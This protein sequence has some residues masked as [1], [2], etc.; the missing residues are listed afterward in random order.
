MPRLFWAMIACWRIAFYHY[1]PTVAYS[2]QAKRRETL[3]LLDNRP[4]GAAITGDRTSA[5]TACNKRAQARGTVP[6]Q[7]KLIMALLS[8][9]Y[10]AD[11]QTAGASLL[12]W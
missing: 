11:R 10:L 3:I 12:M 4:T 5:W 8:L 6:Y 9:Q 2:W 1:R 7:A